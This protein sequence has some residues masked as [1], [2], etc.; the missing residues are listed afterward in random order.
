[1]FVKN[2]KIVVCDLIQIKGS[3]SISRVS[4]QNGISPLYIIVEI[5]HSGRKPSISKAD[6]SV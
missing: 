1:M 5:H 3:A 6:T 4:G 2:V